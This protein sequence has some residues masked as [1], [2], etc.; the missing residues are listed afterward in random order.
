[1]SIIAFSGAGLIRETFFYTQGDYGLFQSSSPSGTARTRPY[2]NYEIIR[3][4]LQ[5]DPYALTGISGKY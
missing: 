1:M 5:K 4:R 2:D 3:R